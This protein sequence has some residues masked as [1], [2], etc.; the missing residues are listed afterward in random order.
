MDALG[1]KIDRA[2]DLIITLNGCGYRIL[3]EFQMWP[4]KKEE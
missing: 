2:S 3:H 1:T 4:L